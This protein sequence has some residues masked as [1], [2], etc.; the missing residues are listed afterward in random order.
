MKGPYATIV[1]VRSTALFGAL[2]LL[3][4]VAACGDDPVGHAPTAV[5]SAPTY[6]VL[7]GSIDLDGGASTD[8]DSDIVSYRFVISDGTATRSFTSDKVT[9]TCKVEGLIGVTLFVHDA[10]GNQDSVSTVVSV[11]PN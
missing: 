6:C 11:R 9:H 1:F 4:V 8:P 10:A 5:I 7:G 2:T 3:Y